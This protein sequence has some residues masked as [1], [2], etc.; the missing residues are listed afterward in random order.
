MDHAKEL[1][2]NRT[3]DNCRHRDPCESRCSDFNECYV[4]SIG[5]H[6]FW[7]GKPLNPPEMLFEC[8]RYSDMSGDKCEHKNH[9][10]RKCELCLDYVMEVRNK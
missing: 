8:C 7:E 3:C 6:R 9:P 10:G 1:I 2:A 4:G 5:F